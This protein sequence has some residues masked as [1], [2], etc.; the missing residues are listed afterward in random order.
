MENLK[1]INDKDYRVDV[2]F[3]NVY[4]MEKNMKM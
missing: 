4:L 3:E 2:D 1:K